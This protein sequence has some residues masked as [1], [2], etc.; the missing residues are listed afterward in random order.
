MAIILDG[1]TTA[2]EVLKELKA[3]V[4]ALRTRGVSPCLAIILTGREK[5]SI[6]YADLKRAQAE[7][8]GVIFKLYHLE[9]TTQEDLENLINKLNEDPKIHGIM[10]QMPLAEGLDELSAVKAIAPSKDVDGL[11]PNTLGKI[12]L[13]GKSYLPAGIEAI[14][15]LLRRYEIKPSGKHWI[16]VGNSNYL[17]KPLAMYLV[18][19]SVPVTLCPVWNPRVKYLVKNADVLCTEIFRKHIIGADMVKDEVIV[20]DNGYS[21]E[22]GKVYGDVNSVAI[23]DKARAITPVPGGVGPMLIAM[24]LRNTVKAARIFYR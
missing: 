18:N 13:G 8:I 23:R 5:H 21:Y 6:R 24:L 17:S 19:M 12:L 7:K 10:I 3:E 9:E 14:M 11:S 1:Y 2:Q 20:I 4:D 16:I 22:G 15:E